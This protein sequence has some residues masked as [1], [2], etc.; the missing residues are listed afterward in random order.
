VP[1]RPGILALLREAV[2]AIFVVARWCR[3]VSVSLCRKELMPPGN[4]VGGGRKCAPRMGNFRT[5]SA[6]AGRAALLSVES[7]IQVGG[8]ERCRPRLPFVSS[9]TV[10]CPTFCGCF[11]WVESEVLIHVARLAEWSRDTSQKQILPNRFMQLE[12]V[13]TMDDLSPSRAGEFGEL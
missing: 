3:I 10:H 6:S 12:R 1:F 4:G 7:V 2:I 5:Q 8:A 13:G 11:G 9:Y